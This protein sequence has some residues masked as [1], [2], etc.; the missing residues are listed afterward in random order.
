MSDIEY[1]PAEI[2]ELI[3]RNLNLSDLVRFKQT[4]QL[5]NG[6]DHLLSPFYGRLCALDANLPVLLPSDNTAK[7]FYQAFTTIKNAQLK[8][9]NVLKA[10]HADLLTEEEKRALDVPNTP[11]DILNSFEANIEILEQ[12]D[13]ILNQINIDLIQSIIAENPNST[14]LRLHK[15]KITRLPI[16]SLQQENNPDYWSNLTF[17]SCINTFITTI[18]LQDCSSLVSFY[19]HH[20]PSLTVLELTG[21]TELENLTLLLSGLQILKLQ[22]L[23]KLKRIVC[24]KNLLV[25]CEIQNM[26]ALT[27]LKLAGNEITGIN[28]TNCPNLVTFNCENNQLSGT[29]DCSGY[30]ALEVME[31]HRND[32]HALVLNDCS[33]LNRLSCHGNVNLSKIELQD[34]SSLDFVYL[35]HEYLTDLTLTNASETF[36]NKYPHL[37]QKSRETNHNNNAPETQ[38]ILETE[39]IEEMEEELTTCTTTTT[40]N[41]TTLSSIFSFVSNQAY[42]AASFLP[43]LPGFVKRT[44]SQRNESNP[45]N[46]NNDNSEGNENLPANKRRR[47]EK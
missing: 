36:K 37:E 9:I 5:F 13:A 33:K 17:L 41:E 31:C 47:T 44:Y 45:D 27:D 26:P 2:M 3:G 30:P 7:A 16:S 32:L 19:C 22:D 43:S 42:Q 38:A 8:E 25:N 20:N 21:C 12:R 24:T 46:E 23:I 40:T 34:C 1:I 11:S 29:L 10:F 6:M 28:I 39:K 15:F 18:N 35:D 4:C 14:E